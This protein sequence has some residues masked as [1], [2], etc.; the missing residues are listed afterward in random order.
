MS[1]SASTIDSKAGA[2]PPD[3]ITAQ[4]TLAMPEVESRNSQYACTDVLR[5]DHRRARPSLVTTVAFDA[6]YGGSRSIRMRGATRMSVEKPTA[7]C[8]SIET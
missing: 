6:T 4:R 3:A 5:V 1:R 7:S 8:A 2:D